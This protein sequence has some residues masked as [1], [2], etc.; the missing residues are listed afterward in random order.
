M[1]PLILITNDDGYYSSGINALIQVGLCFGEVVVVAPDESR[2]GMSHAIT[3]KEPLRINL[4][5]TEKN[6]TI[7]STNG[8]PVDCVKLA[9]NQILKRKPDLL[10]SGINHGSNASVSILYSGTMGAVMEGCINGITSIGFSITDY[11]KN[12]DFEASIF[13]AKKIIDKVI[14]KSI[15]NGSCLNVN[16]PVGT[17]E[18]IKGIKICR[19]TKGLW[20]EEFDKRTDPHKSDYYWL[21]GFF[22]NHEPNDNNTDEWALNNKYISIV[23]AKIDLTDYNEIENLKKWNL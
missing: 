16:I 10:L 18:E 21:T 22:E 8:T 6:L 23:P 12:P 14:E 5:K 1:K 15:T 11:N 20:K 17:L 19:Q 9:I 3:I 7:Y 13:Y 2:S 4:I